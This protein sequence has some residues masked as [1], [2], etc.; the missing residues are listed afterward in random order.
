MIGC[1]LM[2]W[3]ICLRRAGA[4]RAKNLQRLAIQDVYEWSSSDVQEPF[5][6]R[7]GDTPC[8]KGISAIETEILLRDE[9]AVNC[10]YLDSLVSA[11]GNIHKAVARNQ[12]IVRHHK[13]LKDGPDSAQRRA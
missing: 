12:H 11:I 7:Q 6:R 2:T 8:L 10:E 3:G 9:F 5:V 13:L 1:D 4:E